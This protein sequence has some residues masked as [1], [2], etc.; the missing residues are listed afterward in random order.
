MFIPVA[1]PAIP[2]ICPTCKINER[3]PRYDYCQECLRA[4]GREYAVGYR[5]RHPNYHKDYFR[6]REYGL[7]DNVYNTMFAAQNG[8]CA[9]CSRPEISRGT[10]GNIKTLA[11]D[12]DHATG[13][14]RSLLCNSCNLKLGWYESQEFSI[15]SY[16]AK[17]R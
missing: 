15:H 7:T 3:L 5:T 11:I 17:W 10:N 1:I 16:L 14:V 9:I 8:L 6:L 12:H 13:K 2:K 4:H